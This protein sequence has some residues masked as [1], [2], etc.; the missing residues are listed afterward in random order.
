MSVI[1]ASPIPLSVCPTCRA[2]AELSSTHSG[3]YI[4]ECSDLAQCPEWP[5]TDPM[6]TP[7]QAATAWNEGHTH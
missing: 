2:P 6:P 3:E 7:E 1:I 4:V 5:M